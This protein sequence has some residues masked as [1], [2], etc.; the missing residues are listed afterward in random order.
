MVFSA[1]SLTWYFICCSLLVLHFLLLIWWVEYYNINSTM[2]VSDKSSQHVTLYLKSYC[3]QCALLISCAP[4]PK[5]PV[6]SS[7]SF[8]FFIFLVEDMF[9]NIES[10]FLAFFKFIDGHNTQ[11]CTNHNWRHKKDQIL[12]FSMSL[13]SKSL[14]SN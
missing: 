9:L 4:S 6:F 10:T 14:Y 2:L 13:I 5:C 8:F 1:Y 11:T 3:N 7:V 12:S